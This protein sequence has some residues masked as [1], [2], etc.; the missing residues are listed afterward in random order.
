MEESELAGIEEG[1]ANISYAV[2]LQICQG[3]EIRP[4]DFMDFDTDFLLGA[5]SG[6]GGLLD[7]A[8]NHRVGPYEGL[9]QRGRKCRRYF[10]EFVESLYEMKP[11]TLGLREALNRVVTVREFI[12][13]GFE[14]EQEEVCCCLYWVVEGA[15]SIH[16][17]RRYGAAPIGF[18]SRGQFYLEPRSFQARKTSHVLVRAM[19][20]SVVLCIRY[21][22]LIRVLQEYKGFQRVVDKL[23][24]RGK[25]LMDVYD[26]LQ[27]DKSSAERLK[28]VFDAFPEW[29]SGIRVRDLIR[30]IGVWIHSFYE[31]KRE[32][33]ENV[34]R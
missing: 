20:R 24:E 26:G 13:E 5:K 22:D 3:L 9:M 32:Y 34:T 14:M 11:L 27:G 18:I 7:Q 15:M 17:P 28:L 1:K 25:I 33:E 23:V 4:R 19:K 10:E 12:T 6:K 31:A 8:G 2:L 29:A 16:C 21:D 30:Y